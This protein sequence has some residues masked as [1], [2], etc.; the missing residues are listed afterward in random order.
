[1]K[2]KK[3]HN[4]FCWLL[5][6]P[7][8]LQFYQIVLT[9]EGTLQKQFPLSL[10][11]FYFSPATYLMIPSPPPWGSQWVINNLSAP[12]GG[13][14]DWR[15]PVSGPEH[16]WRSSGHQTPEKRRGAEGNLHQA[17]SA[18]KSCCR[19]RVSEDRRQDSRGGTGSHCLYMMNV[20]VHMI[21][22]S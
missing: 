4:Q 19:D 8:F 20:R 10:L 1:M 9:Y 17:G 16:C 22:M 11:M 6:S 3:S 21:I 18:T 14:V 15:E 2:L 7:T 5:R 12:Q 13:G